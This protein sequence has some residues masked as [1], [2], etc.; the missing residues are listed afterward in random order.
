[1]LELTIYSP[2]VGTNTSSM[3]QSPE[4]SASDTSVGN[5]K[6]ESREGGHFAFFQDNNTLRENQVIFSSYILF[7]EYT[8]DGRTKKMHVHIGG[9]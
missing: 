4:F 5:L 1:M 8:S 3:K 6:K 9:K 7:G 2:K